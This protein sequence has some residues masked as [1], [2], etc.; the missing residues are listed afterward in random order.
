MLS[1]YVGLLFAGIFY[2]YNS[3]FYWIILFL[4]FIY[5]ISVIGV[6]SKISYTQIF[7]YFVK[8]KNI[9]PYIVGVI[10]F[11]LIFIG[12]GTNHLIPWDEAIYAKIA[13]NMVVSGDFINM[14][15]KNAA[16]WFE[17][18]PL[19]IW[20]I[21]TGMK[22]FGFSAFAARL[23]SALFGFGTVLLTYLIA[24]KYF[25]K[26]AA[27]ISALALAT[28]VHFLYYSRTAMTD[29]ATTFFIMATLF[30]YLKTIDKNKLHCWFIVG[31]LSGLAVMMKGVVGFLPLPIIGF[32][33][34]T[35]GKKVFSIE[36]LKN[37]LTL[38]IGLVIIVAPWHIVMYQKHG[39]AFI[40]NYFFY[41]VLSRATQDI[42]DKGRPFFWYLTVMK[43]SMRIW[44]IPL[45]AAFPFFIY[46]AVKKESNYLMFVIWAVFIFL[47]FSASKSKIVWYILPIYPVVSIMVGHF[48]D[49]IYRLVAKKV[50]ILNHSII[51]FFVF[52]IISVFSLMYLFFYRHMVYTEDLTGPQANL[53]ML[54]DVEL[55]TDELLYVDR[56]EL[57][58]IIY[59]T[60]GPFEVIDYAPSKMR[61]PLNFYDKDINILTKIGRFNGGPNLYGKEPMIIGQE[62]DYILVSYKSDMTIDKQR[63]KEIDKIIKNIEEGKEQSITNMDQLEKERE[64]IIKRILVFEP[65]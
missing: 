45:I 20:S 8:T 55:G 18:P 52:F 25:G 17:K 9:Y 24:N 34:L 6:G 15:W 19:Y 37:Y 10:A 39:Q 11:F 27:A 61:I 40:D 59:Y 43:V 26:F 23:P 29:V 31:A 65:I 62:G 36:N 48:C 38:L 58:L 53:L 56:I 2:S 46:K 49:Y 5:S 3:E 44:F 60:D 12:L 13:K 54:R 33:E 57:P 28:G 47:F 41:H 63:L 7:D 1:T 42:E 50:K 32:I 16:A 21:A 35:R 22:L 14:T 64:E 30:V 4:Y 51:E